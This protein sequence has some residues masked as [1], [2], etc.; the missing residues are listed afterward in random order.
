VHSYESN[1]IEGMANF[2]IKGQKKSKLF[3]QA[4]ISSKKRTNDFYFKKIKI[5]KNFTFSKFCPQNFY[6]FLGESICVRFLEEIEDTKNTFR[7]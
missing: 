1:S 7:N 2:D 5:S 6:S 3:F 4:D